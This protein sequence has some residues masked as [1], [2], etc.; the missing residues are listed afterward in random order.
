MDVHK[1]LRLL[2][3]ILEIF[4]DSF[5]SQRSLRVNILNLHLL[6]YSSHLT[7]HFPNSFDVDQIIQTKFGNIFLNQYSAGLCNTGAV[8]RQPRA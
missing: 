7:H 1:W 4:H 8:N 3:V 6:E 5:L 2:K